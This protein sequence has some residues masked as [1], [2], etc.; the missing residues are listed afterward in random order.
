MNYPD[1]GAVFKN[2]YKDNERKPDFKGE[3]NFSG[4]VFEVAAWERKDKNGNTYFSLK[5]SEPFNK[6][7]NEQSNN[8]PTNESFTVTET[9]DELPF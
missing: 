3:G 8:K 2:N 4:I 7:V 1:S 6:E 9:E 5:F